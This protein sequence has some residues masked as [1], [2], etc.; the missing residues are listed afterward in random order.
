[1]GQ[2]SASLASSGISSSNGQ[3]DPAKAAE[4]AVVT[5]ADG[6]YQANGVAPGVRVSPAK[7]ITVD[8][9]KSKAW[10][11]SA[12]VTPKRTSGSCA[13]PP[14]AVEE[15]LAVPGNKNGSVLLVLRADQGVPNAVSPSQLDNI[16]ASVRKSS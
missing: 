4:H 5:W 11:A 16:A 1:Q 14:S 13:N 12:Q 7:Q 8:N 2:N 9:G 10:L 15:V 3:P 6:Y